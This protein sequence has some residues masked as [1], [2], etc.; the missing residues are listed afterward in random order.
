MAFA[1]PDQSLANP[2]F[3]FVSVLLALPDPPALSGYLSS[4]GRAA[5][6]SV[7]YADNITTSPQTAPDTFSLQHSSSH[8]TADNDPDNEAYHSLPHP[9]PPR[10]LS[11]QYNRRG[12]RTSAQSFRRRVTFGGW[13]AKGKRPTEAN[14]K[15]VSTTSLVQ[16]VRTKVST[17]F[18]PEHKVGKAPGIM[19]E[20]RTIIFGSCT[21]CR[22][23]CFW[24]VSG[25]LTGLI[26]VQCSFVGHPGFRAWFSRF[27]IS[28]RH[29]L[30]CFVGS[31]WALHFAKPQE[32]TLVFVCT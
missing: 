28:H 9:V 2:R 13:G 15:S 21:S 22:P 5:K 14:E 11:E 29:R 18:V 6:P 25:I 17:L 4:S 19:R 8:H 23:I 27:Q 20:L 24:R 10:S 30:I 31:Q 1:P 26:R 32:Y 7:K 16:T 3:L 12:R